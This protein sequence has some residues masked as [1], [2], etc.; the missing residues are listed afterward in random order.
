LVDVEI[1]WTDVRNIRTLDNLG[2]A[3]EIGM[4][5]RNNLLI[6]DVEGVGEVEVNLDGLGVPAGHVLELIRSMRPE[7]NRL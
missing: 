4:N 2:G 3:Q 7:L 6:L 1:H 5:A